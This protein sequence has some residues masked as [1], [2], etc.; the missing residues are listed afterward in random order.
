MLLGDGER[1]RATGWGRA[2]AKCTIG[3][4]LVVRAVVRQ[5]WEA[6][7][8]DIKAKCAA[9]MPTGL[10][11]EMDVLAFVLADALGQPLLHP[12]DTNLFGKR[13]ATRATRAQKDV[14]K[15]ERRTADAVRKA[16]GRLRTQLRPP[17]RRGK[18]RKSERRC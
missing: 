10:I 9:F 12:D 8:D 14:Y 11:D 17:R 15:E 16:Y 5:L 7:E 3:F 2:V 1:P 18:A 13:I 4:L 6:R